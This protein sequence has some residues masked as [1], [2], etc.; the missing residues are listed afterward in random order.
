MAVPPR[1]VCP[2]LG[3]AVGQPRMQTG[4]RAVNTRL[5]QHC[6][7]KEPEGLNFKV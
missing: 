7:R 1:Q 5:G 3:T 2:G 6:G 4:G